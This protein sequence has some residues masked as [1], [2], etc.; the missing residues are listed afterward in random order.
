MS[1]DKAFQHLVSNIPNVE[2]FRDFVKMVNKM[3]KKSNSIWQLGIKYRKPKEGYK[4]SS[5]GSLKCKNA[6]AFSV[7][8]HDRRPY[9][10]QPNNIYRGELREENYKLEEENKKLKKELA[11]Y[12]NP[13]NEWRVGEIEDEIFDVKQKA[14]EDFLRDFV[15]EDHRKIVQNKYNL[16]MEALAY[17]EENND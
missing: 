1:Q 13:Y 10:E 3:A 6:N 4:Y 12:K 11:F 15:S 7:Y 17:N 5:G 14:G 16:L 9:H 8:I 2:E